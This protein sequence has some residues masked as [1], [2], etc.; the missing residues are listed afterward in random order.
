DSDVSEAPITVVAEQ[1]VSRLT[2]AD[3][4]AEQ[5]EIGFL[6]AVVVERHDHAAEALPDG[7]VQFR[8][9]LRLRP[10]RALGENDLPGLLLKQRD[11]TRLYGGLVDG[12]T[13]NGGGVAAQFPVT[14]LDRG[15][16]LRLF[17]RLELFKELFR[18]LR[19]VV[20]DQRTLGEAVESAL[21]VGG[22]V[23]RS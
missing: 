22:I 19:V 20:A 14:V 9:L 6:V 11:W 7:A 12:T 4:G 21:D 15:K 5:E 8:Q 13:T 23:Q 16:L 1:Q 10:A 18:P 3:H 17:E 2:V